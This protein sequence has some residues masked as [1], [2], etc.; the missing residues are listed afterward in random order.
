MEEFA[1]LLDLKCVELGIPQ[2]SDS[3]LKSI[4][5]QF[6][7]LSKEERRKTSRK[8]RKLS[9]KAIRRFS[10]TAAHAYRLKVGCGF[11]QPT[12][13]TSLPKSLTTRRRINLVKRLLV[14]EIRRTNGKI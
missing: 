3:S 12:D 6:N 13:E 9:K 7:T 11:L 4:T 5:S 14:S 2:L 10:S 1:I 8:I